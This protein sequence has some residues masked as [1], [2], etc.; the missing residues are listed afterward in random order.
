MPV[1]TLLLID[2]QKGF[3]P[4]GSLAIP[5]ASQDAERTPPSFAPIPPFRQHSKS[6]D[7]PV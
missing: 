2:M 1:T 6:T 4:C 3:Y 7:S 5:T